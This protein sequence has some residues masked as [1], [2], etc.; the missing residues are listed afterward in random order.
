MVTISF[1][2]LA[3]V[4][5]MG[6]ECAKDQS[7]IGS[8]GKRPMPYVTVGQ[9]NSAPIE[10]YYEDHDSGQPVALIHGFCPSTRRVVESLE[11]S[12]T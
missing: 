7:L 6:A 1:K 9:E 12:R 2:L 10:I 11:R 5:A 3:C 8:K 4:L